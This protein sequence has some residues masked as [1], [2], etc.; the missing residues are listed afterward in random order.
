MVF[1]VSILNVDTRLLD[2]RNTS[3]AFV[4]VF[5]A[6]LV[7]DSG[8]LDGRV[9]LAILAV[10]ITFITRFL[11]AVVVKTVGEKLGLGLHVRLC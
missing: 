2:P 1:I 6:F 7:D 5:V 9:A 11:E 10:T 3:V 8:F 4:P